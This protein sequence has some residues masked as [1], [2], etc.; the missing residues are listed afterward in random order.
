MLVRDFVS[1]RLSYHVILHIKTEKN[2]FLLAKVV[3]KNY[4][5]ILFFYP[6]LLLSVGFSFGESINS[7][8]LPMEDC[9]YPLK[10]SF[11]RTR[12]FIGF[13]YSDFFKNQS[14]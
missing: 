9:F 1:S 8:N 3:L 7:R 11:L 13:V 6:V 14:L 2:I 4:L 12:C 5:Y 10:M